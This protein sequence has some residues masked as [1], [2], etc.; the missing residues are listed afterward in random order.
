MTRRAS[1]RMA[2]AGAALALTPALARAQA[3]HE[4]QMLNVHP[5][6]KR[7]RQVFYPR[8]QVIQPGDTVTFVAVDK[9]HNSASIDGM[10]PDGADGWNG[11]INED[12]SATLTTPGFYGYQ[13]TPHAT[14]GMVGL[15]VVEG[16]GMLD[17]LDAAMSVR[18]RGKAKASWDEIWEEVSG[19]G[20]TG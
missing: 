18:Q 16:D 14:V 10:I 1:L 19:M 6:N 8:I 11:K 5:E 2:A 9:A 13:C 4:I 3:T 17:N 15:V 7:L 20:L 12:V